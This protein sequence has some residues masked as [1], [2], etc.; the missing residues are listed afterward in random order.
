[1]WSYNGTLNILWHLLHRLLKMKPN[2]EDEYLRGSALT[3]LQVGQ[4]ALRLLVISSA[5]P[6]DLSNKLYNLT[7]SRQQQFQRQQ[8]GQRIHVG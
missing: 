1:M 2:L 8:Y 3:C 5:C 7:R 4:T 6:I